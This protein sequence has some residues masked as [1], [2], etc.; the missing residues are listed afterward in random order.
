M[1]GIKLYISTGGDPFQTK[2]SVQIPGS[3]A[4]SQKIW[5]LKR[6]AA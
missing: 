3:A 2:S 1:N 5:A 4:V 6:M